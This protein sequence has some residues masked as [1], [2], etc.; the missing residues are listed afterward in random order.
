MKGAGT[1]IKVIEACM[2]GRKVIAT[3]FAVRG[4]SQT[5]TE[6]LG[7]ELFAN[8]RE[9]VDVLD[10]WMRKADADLQTSQERTRQH[11]ESLWS[12]DQFANCVRQTFN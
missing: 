3:R 12:F 7:I 8:G 1:C 5:D 9:F 6:S 2:H 11:A 4:I 10:A